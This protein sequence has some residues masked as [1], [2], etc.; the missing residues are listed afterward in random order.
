M[1]NSGI[2]MPITALP[3]PWGVGTMGEEARRFLSFLHRFL[4]SVEDRCL[5]PFPC[6]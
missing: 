4:V 6:R 1:R 2:L 3:S 5:D